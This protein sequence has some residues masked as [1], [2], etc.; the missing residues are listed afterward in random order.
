MVEFD[1]VGLE[2]EESLKIVG[3]VYDAKLTFRPMV[4]EMVSRDRSAIGMLKKLTRLLSDSDLGTIYKY[5]VRS[6]MEYGNASY[7]GAAKSHLEK[8]DAIQHRTEKLS[9]VCSQPLAAR[10]DAACFGLVCKILDGAC[11]AP[12][13]EMCPGF[14]LVHAASNHGYNT[15]SNRALS[16]NSIQV[17]NMIGK[18]RRDGSLRT[19]ERSYIGSIHDIFSKGT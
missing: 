6:K 11:V 19:F 5:F 13:L 3:V 15:S 12:L 4:E 7:R 1:G 14:G 8:L 2:Y 18:A 9:G 16:S 17:T 10:R